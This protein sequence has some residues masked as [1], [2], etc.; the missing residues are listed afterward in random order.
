MTASL[1]SHS[2]IHSFIHSVIHLLTFLLTY[3]LSRPMVLTCLFAVVL[4]RVCSL[5]SN[6][7]RATRA[8]VATDRRHGSSDTGAVSVTHLPSTVCCW[9]RRVGMYGAALQ[10]SLVH[11]YRP[12]YRCLYIFLEWNRLYTTGDNIII[13]KGSY[14]AQDRS[15]TTSTQYPLAIDPLYCKAIHSIQSTPTCRGLFGTHTSSTSINKI[16]W[17]CVSGLWVIPHARSVVLHQM[18]L[19]TAYL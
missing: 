5:H 15:R 2:F 16:W 3:L 4:C 13:I 8:D 1:K 10:I 9:I 19:S 6:K 12:L 17:K 7:G 14:K 11:K 18:T